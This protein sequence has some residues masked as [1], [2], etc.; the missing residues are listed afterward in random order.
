MSKKVIDLLNAARSREL[1]AITQYMAQH[2]ELEDKGFEKLA[3]KMKEIAIQEMKHAEALAERI[4]FLKGVPTTK[5]DSDVQKG[6]DIDGMLATNIKLEAYAVKMYN[7]ASVVCAA[8]KDQVSKLLFEKL[9]S[10]EEDHLN[11]FEN[12]E[13]HVEK[14]GAPYIASLTD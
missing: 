5:P 7:E 10:Q 2:Y 1:T 13:E 12:T 9:L 3:K 8:E 11:F 14:L 4:L 6:Q